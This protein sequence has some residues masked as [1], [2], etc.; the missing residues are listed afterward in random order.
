M[1]VDTIHTGQAI[2]R[3][4]VTWTYQPSG[5]FPGERSD[6]SL[7]QQLQDDWQYTKNLLPF[8][9]SKKVRT[10]GMLSLGAVSALVP[11]LE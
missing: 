3:R 9:G 8:L 6:P 5:E 11:I 1:L 10:Q 7:A 2:S 4:Q